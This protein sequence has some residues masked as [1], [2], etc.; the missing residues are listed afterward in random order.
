MVTTRK[1]YRFNG[2]LIFGRY[3]IL[4]SYLEILVF[5]LYHAYGRKLCF[6][7]LQRREKYQM[8]NALLG[9]ITNKHD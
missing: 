5:I 9:D 3:C 6:G 7:Y 8:A 1:A 4:K 2:W